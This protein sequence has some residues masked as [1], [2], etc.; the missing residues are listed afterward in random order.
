MDQIYRPVAYVAEAF[1]DRV[2]GVGGC[3]GQLVDPEAAV[4]AEVDDVGERASRV[5]S[6]LPTHSCCSSTTPGRSR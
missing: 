4:I 1:E 5:D 3:G 6:Y 2:R